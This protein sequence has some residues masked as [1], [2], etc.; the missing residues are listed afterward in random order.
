MWSE[1]RERLSRHPKKSRIR[2]RDLL[3][4]SSPRQNAK[5]DAKSA[6]YHISMCCLRESWQVGHEDVLGYPAPSNKPSKV[7]Q[8][9]EWRFETPGMPG[10]A[11]VPSC[12]LTRQAQ[13]LTRAAESR[14]STR[15]AALR[16]G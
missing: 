3:A 14:Q 4:V 7:L 12:I 8:Q 5:N 11:E 2:R 9:V 10:E 16:D 15:F 13:K 1:G 6:D